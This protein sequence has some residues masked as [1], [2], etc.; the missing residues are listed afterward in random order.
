MKDLSPFW[1][2]RYQLQLSSYD[3]ERKMEGL[4]SV[5][6]FIEPQYISYYSKRLLSTLLIQFKLVYGSFWQSSMHSKLDFCPLT[7]L[8]GST[9][10]KIFQVRN[11]IAHNHVIFVTLLFII[12]DKF[13]FI[14]DMLHKIRNSWQLGLDIPHT[15]YGTFTLM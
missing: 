7:S 8:E 14:L 2:V 9:V 1:L 4:F 15:N 11:E 12:L 10:E 6:F 3:Y 5:W 13:G